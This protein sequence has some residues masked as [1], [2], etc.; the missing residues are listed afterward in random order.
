ML[1][2]QP[3]LL[4]LDE[5]VAGLDPQGRAELAAMIADLAQRRHLTTVLVGNTIDELAELADRAIIMHRGQVVMEGPLHDLMERADELHQ[6][7]LELSEAAQIAL[8]L[9]DA[10]PVLPTNLLR[11]DELERALL[12]QLPESAFRADR[13]QATAPETS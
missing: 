9:R 13:K 10:I 4:I 2:A 12:A 1:A 11:I 6:L 8:V 3:K 5:P 7:G